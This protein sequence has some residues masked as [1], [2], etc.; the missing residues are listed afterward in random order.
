MTLIVTA[1]AVKTIDRVSGEIIMGDFIKRIAFTCVAEQT[2]E[3]DIFAYIGHNDRIGVTHCHI[4]RVAPG[5]AKRITA[6]VS[7]A[8]KYQADFEKKQGENP[9]AVTDPKR[10]AIG[11][12]LF[13]RQIHRSDLKAVKNIGAGQFGA[14][15]L[16]KQIVPQGEG[17]DNGTTITRAVKIMMNSATPADKTEFLRE[18]ET[19]LRMSD[20]NLVSLIGV[21]VQQ[22]PWLCV[23]EFMKYGDLH[24][25]LSACAEK[26][27]P[28]NFPEQLHFCIQLA[29]GLA[30]MA[31]L[32]LIHMDVAARNCMMTANN[33]VKV[34]DFGLTREMDPGTDHLIL[35]EKLRLPIKWVAIEGKSTYPTEID[36]SKKKI[37]C[38]SL[39]GPCFVCLSQV[40]V[41]IFTR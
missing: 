4:F 7:L 3:H 34:G 11:G 15:Y 8:F 28:L 27:L 32:R 20:R 5:I 38:L 39:A 26:N 10:E 13:Y 6:A 12:E 19:M 17:D 21:A 35:R 16:A 23:L 31:S 30:H 33:V 36:E 14:V 40:L 24:E 1:T 25:V 41:L 22:K 18:A 2:E 9:F 37:V 29:S